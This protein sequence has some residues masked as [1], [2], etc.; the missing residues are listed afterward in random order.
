MRNT[1]LPAEMTANCC[2]DLL[3][4]WLCCEALAGCRQAVLAVADLVAS[5]TLADEAIKTR[6]CVSHSRTV[7]TFEEG[8]R[9][10]EEMKSRLVVPPL[11]AE[12]AA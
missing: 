5:N 9:C 7:C 10:E 6:Y 4:Q 8:R 12:E 1:W 2:Q 11:R 3:A